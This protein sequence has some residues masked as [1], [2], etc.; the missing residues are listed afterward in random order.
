[1]TGAPINPKLSGWQRAPYF[2][3]N[4]AVWAGFKT[5]D[6]VKERFGGLP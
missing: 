1:M 2:Q 6:F 3:E 5:G 4:T